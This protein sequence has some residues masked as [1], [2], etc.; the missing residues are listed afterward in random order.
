MGDVALPVRVLALRQGS[1]LAYAPVEN[2][3][4]PGQIPLDAMTNLIRAD[5]LRQKTQIYG[6]IGNPITPFVVAS[7]SECWFPSTQDGCGI[8]SVSGSRLTGFL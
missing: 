8:S 2:A 7:A 3:T 6:V 5:K 4:A 1:A